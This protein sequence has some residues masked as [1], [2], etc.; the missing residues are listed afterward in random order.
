MTGVRGSHRQAGIALAIKVVGV[1][2]ARTCGVDAVRTV[3]HA[4]NRRA[5]VMNRRLGYVDADW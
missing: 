1:N 4:G 2:Y 3:Q 5:T